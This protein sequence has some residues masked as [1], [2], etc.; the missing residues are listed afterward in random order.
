MCCSVY[1]CSYVL[2]I[3][4]GRLYT[5]DITAAPHLAVVSGALALALVGCARALVLYYREPC[6]RANFG[7]SAVDLWGDGLDC[8][9]V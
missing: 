8:L 4:K 1:R 3:N 7:A 5:V 6:N 9:A 2:D